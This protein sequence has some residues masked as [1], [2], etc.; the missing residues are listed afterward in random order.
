MGGLGTGWVW[1]RRGLGVDLMVLAELLCEFAWWFSFAGARLKGK[2]AALG[3]D[4][5]FF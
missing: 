3:G 4:A 1:F 5:A 2:A